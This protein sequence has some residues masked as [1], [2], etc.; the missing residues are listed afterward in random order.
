[1][2]RIAE[3]I[4]LSWGGKRILLAFAAGALAVLALPPFNFFAVLFISFPVLVWL[5]DGASGSAE[6]GLLGRIRPAFATGWWFGFGYFVAGLWW[7]GNALLVDASGFAWALPLAVLGLPAILALFYGLATATAW[8]LWSD[9]IG[10]IAALGAAFGLIEWLR[11]F[12]LT[13]FPWN[14]MGYAAM[15]APL[16]MQ[17]VEFVGLFGMSALTVFVFSA[18]ALVGTRQGAVTG[19]VAA[20]VLF[21][22]HLGYGWFALYRLDSTS[23]VASNA[24]VRIVQPAID[25]SAKWDLEARERIF[26]RLLAFSAVPPREGE[27]RPTHIIW[28]ETALPFLLT[29]N[30]GALSRIADMLQVGQ[31]LV[32]GAVRFED[33][34]GGAPQR[35]YNTIYVIDDEGQIIGSADKAHLVPFGEYLPFENLLR[36]F[37][38]TPV[39]ETFGGFSAADRRGLLALPG[40]L[41]AVPL[42][43]YEAIF[44]A[45]SSVPEARGDLLLNLT[46]DAWYGMTPGPY[47]HLRQAQLRAVETRSP[48]VRAANNGISAV[49]DTGGRI[50]GS[51]PLGEAGVFDVALPSPSDQFLLIRIRRFNFG[52]IIVIMV[53]MA[54][55][56]RRSK[57]QRFD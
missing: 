42:I 10:R 25:Q 4:M 9:G 43:C 18:P 26:A 1:M 15:P 23:A 45:L 57:N 17:S 6:R 5:L 41:G 52:L 44:P 37:G 2:E 27:P 14:A 19:L 39:A 24:I 49:V 7:L 20:L 8:L 53:V 22:A 16:M 50:I 56:A 12:V 54:V 46:N 35:Y 11:S 3:S 29:E 31:T 32:T 51:L 40:G 34:V 47:Q 36:R 55:V 13:G 48:L 21:S 38:F 33:G 30:P 28:P